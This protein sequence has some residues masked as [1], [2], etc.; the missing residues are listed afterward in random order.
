MPKPSKLETL[1][2]R[3]QAERD[4][5]VR[6]GGSLHGYILRYGSKHDAEH[7]GDGGEAIYAAD[8]AALAAIEA[9][10]GRAQARHPRAKRNR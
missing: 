7:F 2:R 9:D 6:H 5:I 4:W 1:E 3:L 10:V 8:M